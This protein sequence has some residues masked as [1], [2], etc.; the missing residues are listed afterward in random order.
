MGSTKDFEN[1]VYYLATL[2]LNRENF[3]KVK[4]ILRGNQEMIFWKLRNSF[5]VNCRKSMTPSNALKCPK[6]GDKRGLA[7]TFF[8]FSKIFKSTSSESQAQDDCKQ[9]QPCNG[10][11]KVWNK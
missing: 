5:C 10:Y 8:W 4:T 1:L 11:A 2:G 9:K 7:Q 6:C 3:D